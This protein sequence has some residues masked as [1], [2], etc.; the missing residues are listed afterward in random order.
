MVEV[1]VETVSR[2]E[3]G[4]TIPSLQRLVVIAQTLGAGV[5][6]LLGEAS[7]PRE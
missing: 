5:G 6:E 3:R 7:P 4:N 1:D 2:I